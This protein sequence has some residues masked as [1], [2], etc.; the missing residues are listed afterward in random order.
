MVEYLYVVKTVGSSFQG[1][2]GYNINEIGYDKIVRLN[3]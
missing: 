1:C 3:E 2:V